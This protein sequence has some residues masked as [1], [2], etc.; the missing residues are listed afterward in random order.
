LQDQYHYISKNKHHG[1]EPSK[2]RR[3]SLVRQKLVEAKRLASDEKLD[4]SKEHNDA[5]EVL[6]T[7]K[8]LFLKFL[9][10]PNP[11]LS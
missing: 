9:E 8:D 5:L 2:E 4:Q 7:N 3:M 1:D 11:L 10:E 6:N